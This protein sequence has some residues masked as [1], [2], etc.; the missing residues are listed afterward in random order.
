MVDLVEWLCIFMNLWL[1][2]KK[3]GGR[4]PSGVCLTN[5]ATSSEYMSWSFKILKRAKRGFAE[6]RQSQQPMA[7][8]ALFCRLV[9]FAK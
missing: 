7:R 5:L 6:V 8:I 9:N 4:R 2:T 1:Q 3:Y